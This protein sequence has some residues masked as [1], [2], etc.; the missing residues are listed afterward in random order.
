MFRLRKY[1]L[2][3]GS[4]HELDHTQEPE[5]E[6]HEQEVQVDQNIQETEGSGAQGNNTLPGSANDQ[7]NASTDESSMTQPDMSAFWE[8][9]KRSM[10]RVGINTIKFSDSDEIVRVT[11]HPSSAHLFKVID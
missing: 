4:S 7:N 6:P 11:Y 10:V 8:F 1:I 9:D 3:Q 2:L 5:L